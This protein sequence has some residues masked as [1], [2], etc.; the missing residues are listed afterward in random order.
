MECKT[1]G[2]ERAYDLFRQ[3]GESGVCMSEEILCEKGKQLAR[4]PDLGCQ[5]A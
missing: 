4:M 2:C 3:E 5:I 1:G